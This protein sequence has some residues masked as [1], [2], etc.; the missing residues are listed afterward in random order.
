MC[1][2]PLVRPEATGSHC[3][4]LIDKLPRRNRIPGANAV[5]QCVPPSR[6]QNPFFKDFKV[7]QKSRFSACLSQIWTSKG[8]SEGRG[9]GSAQMDNTIPCLPIGT[10]SAPTKPC[11][12]GVGWRTRHSFGSRAFADQI[13]SANLADCGERHYRDKENG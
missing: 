12:L 10:S 4:V 3:D 11:Y 8:L 2:A 9:R 5:P 1:A 7:L 13:G 6:L